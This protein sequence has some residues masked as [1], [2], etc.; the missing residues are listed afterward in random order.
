TTD[1]HSENPRKTPHSDAHTDK[2]DTLKALTLR[3]K[4]PAEPRDSDNS[5]MPGLSNSAFSLPNGLFVA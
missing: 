3:G 4:K 2:S 5:G 1:C